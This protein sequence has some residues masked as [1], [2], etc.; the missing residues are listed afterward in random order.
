MI[1]LPTIICTK[2]NFT[3]DKLVGFDDVGR[4]DDFTTVDLARR[5]SVRGAIFAEKV[6]QAERE[7]YVSSEKAKSKNAVRDN[8]TGAAVYSSRLAA[9]ADTDEDAD[10]WKDDD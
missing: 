10:F 4:K 7:G 5:L 2:D 1:V 3:S 6:D 9:A 8:P